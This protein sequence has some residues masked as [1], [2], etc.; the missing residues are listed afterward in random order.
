MSLPKLYT[1]ITYKKE[2]I[3][4]FTLPSFDTLELHEIEKEKFSDF[5]DCGYIS[6]IE[7]ET[8][9]EPCFIIFHNE[10]FTWSNGL[11]DFI[12]DLPNSGY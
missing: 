7:D 8:S 10:R 9:T 4:A 12:A 11:A 2:P 6:Q 5:V 1:P 3:F